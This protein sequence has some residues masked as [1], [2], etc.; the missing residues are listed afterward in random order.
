MAH[1]LLYMDDHDNTMPF[2]SPKTTVITVAPMA[3][4]SWSNLQVEYDLTMALHK[5]LKTRPELPFDEN[6]EKSCEES[7]VIDVIKKY[8]T[9]VTKSFSIQK[10]E[11]A[12]KLLIF[13]DPDP[14]YGIWYLD[15]EDGP[16]NLLDTTIVFPTVGEEDKKMYYFSEILEILQSVFSNSTINILDYSCSSCL[17][18][19]SEIV[20]NSNSRTVRR[21][22]RR[23]KF[24]LDKKK[25]KRT[26][27]KKSKK[28]SK[29]SS[30]NSKD[31]SIKIQKS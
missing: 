3:R 1:G 31:R 25:P 27:H 24:V 22:S 30:S 20:R 26:L 7:G 8:P 17:Y 12:N 15:D 6:V 19:N 29:S 16:I 9:H 10:D 18:P 21:L 28:R 11:I 4:T 14:Y 5:N 2:H 23:M 13:D